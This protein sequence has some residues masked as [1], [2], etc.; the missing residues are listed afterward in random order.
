[1]RSGLVLLGLAVAFVVFVASEAKAQGPLGQILDRLD[2]YNKNLSS[3]QADITMVKTDAG[4][5][6]YD[7]TFGSTNYLPKNG[8][9]LMYVRIDWTKPVEESI[10]VIGDDYKLYRP[11]LKQAYVGKADKAKN[12]ASAGGALAF[13]SM[14]KEQLK[15]TYTVVYIGEEQISGGT[16]TWHLQLTPKAKSSY[17]MADIWVTGDGFPQQAMVTENNKDTTTILLKNVHSNIKIDANVFA[18]KWP[19]GTK[20]IKG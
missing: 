1:M 3:L 2:R 7:T 14:S 13:I 11:R 18:L 16:T 12:S 10:V 20:V 8:K 17:K 5:G 9:H 19:D 15:A 4:L 6:V